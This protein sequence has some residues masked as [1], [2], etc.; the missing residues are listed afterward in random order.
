MENNQP[1]SPVVVIGFPRSGTTLLLHILISS[2]KF[3]EYDF[4]E[5]HFF[6][7]YYRRY[8]SLKNKKNKETFISEIKKSEWF[9]N[10]SI[11]IEEI[12]AHTQSDDDQYESY[13]KNFMALVARQNNKTR[14]VEKTPYHMLYIPELR[15]ALPDARFILMMRDPRDVTQSVLKYGWS[16]GLFGSIIKVAAAWNWHINH[17]RQTLESLG[18]PYLTVKYEDLTTQ[19]ESVLNDLNK[20]LDLDLDIQELNKNGMG[21]LRRSNSSYTTQSADE[22]KPIEEGAKNQGISTESIGRWRQSMPADTILDVEYITKNN[23]EHYGYE[24]TSAGK[25][26]LIRRLQIKTLIFFYWLQKRIRSL[27][28]PLVRR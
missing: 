12:I 19:T 15:K 23:C 16:G 18:I 24:I 17:T 28:F 26:T 8:G 4:S 6:S 3:P 21:V 9:Q 22:P 1:N 14:W 5:T 13:Y 20:F 11:S 7:H 25:P 10:S 2:G 27:L